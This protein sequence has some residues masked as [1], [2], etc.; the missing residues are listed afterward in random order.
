VK[1]WFQSFAFKFNVYRY[2]MAAR[3]LA[4]L[5]RYHGDAAAAA[6]MLLA[7]EKG[8]ARSALFDS[9]ALVIVGLLPHVPQRTARLLTGMLDV[10]TKRAIADIGQTLRLSALLAG[11]SPAVAGGVMDG[12]DR[13][14][15][16]RLVQTAP[17][18][19]V[20]AALAHVGK[21]LK[22][23]LYKLDAADP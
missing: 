12:L 10:E 6:T 3:A 11:A 18:E 19:A 14:D 16:V 4:S 1:T 2:N 15:A 17:T 5:R 9:P 21:H 20:A 23:G 22:A 13:T 8:P 7:A